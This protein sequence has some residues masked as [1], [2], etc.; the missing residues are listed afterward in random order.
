MDLWGIMEAVEIRAPESPQLPSLI[1]M[2][3]HSEWNPDL[4]GW[5]EESSSVT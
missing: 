5:N 1:R 2:N 4:S 3:C